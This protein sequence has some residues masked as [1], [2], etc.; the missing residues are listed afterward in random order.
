MLHPNEAD[1]CMPI[2]QADLARRI[3]RTNTQLGELVSM[4]LLKFLYR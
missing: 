2:P 4:L 3:A 1:P